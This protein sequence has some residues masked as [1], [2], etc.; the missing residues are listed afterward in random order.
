MKARRFIRHLIAVMAVAGALGVVRV[1]AQSGPPL[2]NRAF[3]I[4]WRFIPGGVLRGPVVAGSDGSVY[5]QA[6]DWYLYHISGGGAV[7]NRFDLGAAPGDALVAGSDGSVVTTTANGD[8]T[9]VSSAG[10]RLWRIGGSAIN[11]AAGGSGSL[12]PLGAVAKSN[13]LIYV[14]F[15]QGDLVCINAAGNL[16]WTVSFESHLAMLRAVAGGLLVSDTTGRLYSFDDSG[17]VLWTIRLSAPVVAADSDRGVTYAITQDGTIEAVNSSGGLLW[18]RSIGQGGTAQSTFVPTITIDTDG[19]VVATG[20]DGS[21]NSY[22][23]DGTLRYHAFLPA[24]R[25]AGCARGPGGLLYVTTDTGLIV[26]LHSDG[27]AAFSIRTP[28][29]AKL[30]VPWIA[31]DRQIVTGADTWVVYAFDVVG[32]LDSPAAGTADSPILSSRDSAASA[33]NASSAAEPYLLGSF[34]RGAWNGNA[35]YATLRARIDSQSSQDRQDVIDEI[36]RRVQDHRLRTAVPYLSELLAR[37][38][39]APFIEGG[40]AVSPLLRAR[41]VTLLG[42]IGTTAARSFLLKLVARETDSTVL[43]SEIMSLGRFGGDADGS[44]RDALMSIVASQDPDRPDASVGRAIVY[45]L[46]SI[47]RV[48]GT[49]DGTDL[50]IVDGLLSKSYPGALKAEMVKLLH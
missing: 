43:A 28:E 11:S 24:T 13:R 33:A 39:A 41:A 23:P 38:A 32:H 30:G 25:F 15:R 2:P 29:P 36:A 40:R 7:I 42:T 45:C 5:F 16:L 12:A 17:T 34:P 49:L 10:K 47:L 19:D 35:D 14:A 26:A 3:G 9:A 6:D 8:I 4:A 44:V 46:R 18:A 20:E 27:T 31:G 48:E 50:R 37:V 1:D 21:L 22:R